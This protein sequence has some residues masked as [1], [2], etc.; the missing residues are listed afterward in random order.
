MHLPQARGELGPRHGPREC[1]KGGG[2]VISTR[3]LTW[4]GLGNQAAC[5][6]SQTALPP[7]GGRAISG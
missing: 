6:Q 2:I 5:K 3:E 1:N 4:I 7:E